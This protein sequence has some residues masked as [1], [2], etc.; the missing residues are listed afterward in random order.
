MIANCKI[1][2]WLFFALKT[3][4]KNKSWEC[5]A[6]R[7]VWFPVIQQVF[8]TTLSQPELIIAECVRHLLRAM[9]FINQVRIHKSLKKPVTI[10]YSYKFI[11]LT[12]L[13]VHPSFDGTRSGGT[14]ITIHGWFGRRHRFSFAE[15]FSKIRGVPAKVF[16]LAPTA[17]DPIDGEGNRLF[18]I[19]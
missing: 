4:M 2:W 17:K 10:Y 1:H 19:E 7:A 16:F 12:W 5:E 18:W 3:L 8:R 15:V 13:F 11:K 9:V 6:K 14:A